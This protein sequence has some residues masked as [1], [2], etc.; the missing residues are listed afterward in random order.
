[1]RIVQLQSECGDR[2][3]IFTFRDGQ[4]VAK[5]GERSRVAGFAEAQEFP[6][7][8]FQVVNWGVFGQTGHSKPPSMFRKQCADRRFYR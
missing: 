2:G 4:R 8:L 3:I 5:A 1:L 7:L 6:G